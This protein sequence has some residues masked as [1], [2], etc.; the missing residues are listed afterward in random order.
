N[1]PKA[2]A[3]GSPPPGPGAR[4]VYRPLR[5]VCCQFWRSKDDRSA[6]KHNV[7]KGRPFGSD[8]RNAVNCRQKTTTVQFRPRPMECFLAKITVGSGSGQKS[9]KS[10][11]TIG[12]VKSEKNERQE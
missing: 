1:W 8:E 7:G 6:G 4:A 3:E 11:Q 5:K 10:P 2:A 12:S 9:G